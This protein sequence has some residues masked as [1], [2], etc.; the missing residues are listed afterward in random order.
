[1]RVLAT[2]RGDSALLEPARP[3]EGRDGTEDWPD[4]LVAL[5]DAP[6]ERALDMLARGADPRA[7]APSGRT[8]LMVACAR[9]EPRLVRALLDAGADPRAQEAD[10]LTALSHAVAGGSTEV[11][12]ALL[13]A[14]PDLKLQRIPEDEGALFAARLAHRDELL[15]LLAE[16]GALP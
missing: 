8:A 13:G 14:A 7:V 11:V 6:P 2:L 9:G 16:R 5:R 10:S 12:R 15:A 4:L 1:V 3:D